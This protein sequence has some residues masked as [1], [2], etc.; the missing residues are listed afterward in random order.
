MKSSFSSK[1]PI[2]SLP[3]LAPPRTLGGVLHTYVQNHPE[4][5][6]RSYLS[7]LRANIITIFNG[8]LQNTAYTA[9]HTKD[10]SATTSIGSFNRN[11]VLKLVS[12]DFCLG[13]SYLRA[14]KGDQDAEE[15]LQQCDIQTCVLIGKKLRTTYEDRVTD[16]RRRNAMVENE[17]GIDEKSLGK[18]EVKCAICY[19]IT[20][21]VGATSSGDKRF[22]TFG[23]LLKENSCL[24]DLEEYLSLANSMGVTPQLCH[25]KYGG[26]FDVLFNKI[27]RNVDFLKLAVFVAVYAHKHGIKP[28]DPVTL[29]QVSYQDFENDFEYVDDEWRFKPEE[30]K[31]YQQSCEAVF[32]ENKKAASLL[33]KMLCSLEYSI[34]EGEKLPDELDQVLPRDDRQYAMGMYPNQAILKEYGRITPNNAHSDLVDGVYAKEVRRAKRTMNSK[35]AL[36]YTV[37]DVLNADEKEVVRMAREYPYAPEWHTL[38]ID[39]QNPIS[40]AKAICMFYDAGSALCRSIAAYL[41]LQVLSLSEFLYEQKWSVEELFQGV[42]IDDD[43]SL[44]PSKHIFEEF[45]PKGSVVMEVLTNLPRRVITYFVEYYSEAEAGMCKHTPVFILLDEIAQSEDVSQFCQPKYWHPRHGIQAH[46]TSVGSEIAEEIT[47]VVISSQPHLWD[48]SLDYIVQRNLLPSAEHWRQMLSTIKAIFA[49]NKQALTSHVLKKAPVEHISMACIELMSYM[50][51]P[52]EM[53]QMINADKK[54]LEAADPETQQRTSGLMRSYLR[55]TQTEL[56]S[57]E[58]LFEV[59]ASATPQPSSKQKYCERLDLPLSIFLNP[60]TGAFD[61]PEEWEEAAQYAEMIP[62][63]VRKKI[64]T[65]VQE[66]KESNASKVFPAHFTGNDVSFVFTTKESY[67]EDDV[68]ILTYAYPVFGARLRDVVCTKLMASP[69]SMQEQLLEVLP[70][71]SSCELVVALLSHVARGQKDELSV[72][73]LNLDTWDYSITLPSA[74]SFLNKPLTSRSELAERV[75][76][77]LVGRQGVKLK[78]L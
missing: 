42:R 57:D 47:S 50:L 31:A 61:P 70:L 73:D 76:D 15:Y 45:A 27:H 12:D 49:E 43:E 55:P 29:P 35:A 23:E 13:V 34:E 52:H 3:A 36:P 59:D 33:E 20:A 63:N 67:D 58:P 37:K 74:Y 19:E 64:T 2:V 24:D 39:E 4:A 8:A 69:T 10:E 1:R 9:R 78:E 48:K 32:P 54:E 17:G 41:L 25:E 44:Q 21:N 77:V 22:T 6:T 75:R 26:G 68:L 72:A 38:V 14:K 56:E 66:R 71:D 30:Y 5:R 40:L 60:H 65:D 7:T 51:Q 62:E 28:L 53:F 16:L 18:K 11:A 46:L